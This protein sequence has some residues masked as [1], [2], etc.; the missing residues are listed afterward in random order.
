MDKTKIERHHFLNTSTI[1]Q[2]DSD[3]DSSM[4]G[5]AAIAK[6][7]LSLDKVGIAR[8]VKKDNTVS[9]LN[10]KLEML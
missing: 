8:F 5:I 7:L 3:L 9:R 1:L 4:V 6:S 2:G 10:I